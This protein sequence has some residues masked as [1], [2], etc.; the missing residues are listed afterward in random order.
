M[1]GAPRSDVNTNGDLGLLLTL[2]TAQG[3]QFVAADWMG[4]RCAFLRPTD[5]QGGVIEFDLILRTREYLTNAEIARLTEAAKANRW[6]HRDATM[7]LV[8]YRHGF[9]AS[10][11]VDLRWESAFG[12]RVGVA[13]VRFSAVEATSLRWDFAKGNSPSGSITVRIMDEIRRGFH[14]T[15]ANGGGGRTR[16][17]VMEIGPNGASSQK[18]TRSSR[19][20]P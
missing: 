13:T 17:S 8:A 18:A 16:R 10:E 19:T 15:D 2:E 14:T 20:P 4:R 12:R 7:I 9:R 6:A 3:A 5:S 11:L 1:N